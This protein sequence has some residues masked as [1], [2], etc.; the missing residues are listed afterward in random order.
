VKKGGIWDEKSTAWD[1]PV[2]R[3]YKERREGER[4]RVEKS[5]SVGAKDVRP[6]TRERK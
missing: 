6:E 5:N 2:K 3:R 4:T 1:T